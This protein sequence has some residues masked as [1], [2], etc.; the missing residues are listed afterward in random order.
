MTTIIWPQTDD[1][2]VLLIL[3][4]KTLGLPHTRRPEQN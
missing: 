2:P 1:V 3:E 4:F